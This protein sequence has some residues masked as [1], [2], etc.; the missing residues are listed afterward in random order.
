MTMT[1][2]SVLSKCPVLRI[3]EPKKFCT[4]PVH[5]AYDSGKCNETSSFFY[6]DDTLES[7]YEKFLHQENSSSF[8]LVSGNDVEFVKKLLIL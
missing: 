6:S 1:T 2:A 5:I 3:T 7:F 4:R 8:V